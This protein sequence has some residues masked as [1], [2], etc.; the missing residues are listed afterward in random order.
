MS[1]INFEL[2][3]CHIYACK[4]VMST[5]ADLLTVWTKYTGDDV[6]EARH[7][8][9]A[10][11]EAG[12]LPSRKQPLTYADIARTLIGFTA[13]NQHKDAAEEVLAHSGYSCTSHRSLSGKPISDNAAL[14]PKMKLLEAL[15]TSLQPP[16]RVLKFEVNPMNFTC[17]LRVGEGHRKARTKSG[18]D[19]TIP[20]DILILNFWPGF[21]FTWLPAYQRVGLTRFI[22]FPLVDM[23]LTDLMGHPRPQYMVGS[24]TKGAALPGATPHMEPSEASPKAAPEE[25]S[26]N[27]SDSNPWVW[28][29]QFND[30]NGAYANEYGSIH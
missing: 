16:F 1:C 4:C 10:L 28:P 26:P 30:P 8:I 7:R 17:T 13:A 6:A 27:S 29:P 5:K 12:L 23:L 2:T 11:S 15:A 18:K 24:V 20:N 9:R 25:S 3:S 21:N 14:L 22:V 19:V